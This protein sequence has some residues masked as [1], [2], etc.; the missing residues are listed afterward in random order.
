MSR[1]S[2]IRA[3]L[4]EGPD[5]TDAED[6]DLVAARA[7]LGEP[8]IV[9]DELRQGMRGDVAA[10]LAPTLRGYSEELARRKA[11]YDSENGDQAVPPYALRYEG[12]PKGSMARAM[13]LFNLWGMEMTGGC[14]GGCSFCSVCAVPVHPR[15]LDPI[16]EPQ[17]EAMCD[18]IFDLVG[19]L[20]GNPKLQIGALQRLANYLATDSGDYLFLREFLE[21]L[22]KKGVSRVFLSS[23]LPEH[24]RE[25]LEEIMKHLQL[26][27]KIER[28]N[29]LDGNFNRTRRLLGERFPE[30]SDLSFTQAK[31][32]LE[33]YKKLLQ[34]LDI[35]NSLTAYVEMEFGDKTLAEIL[36]MS[37]KGFSSL[38]I[39][40]SMIDQSKTVREIIEDLSAQAQ[41]ELDQ[42]SMRDRGL[43]DIIFD[44]SFERRRQ[45]LKFERELEL[46]LYQDNP[47]LDGVARRKAL[48]EW[49]DKR[50]AICQAVLAEISEPESAKRLKL[51]FGVYRIVE[52]T[53]ET[54][55]PIL[56]EMGEPSA[57]EFERKE[58]RREIVAVCIRELEGRLKKYPE[59][60]V[61]RVSKI[62]SRAEY[63]DGLGL[64]SRH[65]AA[66]YAESRDKM[67][68]SLQ[69]I[70]R[71]FSPPAISIEKYRMGIVVTPYGVENTVLVRLS[72]DCTAG[73][74]RVPFYRFLDKPKPSERGTH[75]YDVLPHVIVVMSKRMEEKD[76][77]FAF[78]GKGVRKIIFDK[79]VYTVITDEVLPGL[80]EVRSLDDVRR[81]FKFRG[82][83][84]SKCETC[85]DCFGI[86]PKRPEEFAA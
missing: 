73:L 53:I 38:D 69:N 35:I 58:N 34:V 68:F 56:E 54:Y 41:R 43:E 75:L 18:E 29:H 2:T 84:L 81:L 15:K 39:I 70:G 1:L 83:L 60:L 33:H 37:P 62:P 3:Y 17:L 61:F 49:Q 25:A 23:I 32:T 77:F 6:H 52:E 24:N 67:D 76:F 66:L 78:D 31:E 21:Y 26:K 47:A 46:G 85:K 42:T 55:D 65:T 20:T 59:D 45:N 16:P 8:D 51:A 12:F 4:N 10:R 82:T 50:D 5:A 27:E 9:L 13:I 79:R 28:L 86:V 71:S 44:M 11:K 74:L 14:S 64:P 63:I 80:E 7:L 72:T 48:R 40:P 30:C 36:R 57:S 22:A 19:E